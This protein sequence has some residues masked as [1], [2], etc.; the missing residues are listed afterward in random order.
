MQSLAAF[1]L[2]TDATDSGSP[3]TL[4]P[5]VIHGARTVQIDFSFYQQF[6]LIDSLWTV[7]IFFSGVIGGIE[8][9]FPSGQTIQLF[10]NISTTEYFYIPVL[11]PNPIRF[12]VTTGG[13]GTWSLQLMNF[14]QPWIEPT[15]LE[16]S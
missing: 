2:P 5:I 12:T 8:L 6:G 13:I 1:P 14:V 9:T 15:I 11:C 16:R 10:S 3:T 4:A 7:G